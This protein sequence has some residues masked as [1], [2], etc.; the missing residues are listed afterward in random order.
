MTRPLFHVALDVSSLERSIDFYRRVLGIAPDKVRARYARFTWTDPPLVLS[1]NEGM[2][3][4]RGGQVA[5]MGVRV[6][7]KAELDEFR[8]RVLAADVPIREE[9]EIHCCHAVEN[10]VWV[11]DP[12]GMEWEFYELVDDLPQPQAVPAKG[13]C[14]S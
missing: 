4:R 5:H 11:T 7:S 6:G 8:R 13:G 14:C 1:L 3:V 2:R 12:D 9:H 10:K